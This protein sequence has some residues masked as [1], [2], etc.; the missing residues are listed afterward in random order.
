MLC[1]G[2]TCSENRLCDNISVFMIRMHG[3]VYFDSIQDKINFCANIIEQDLTRSK[4]SKST[5]R[6]VT[7]SNMNLVA[8]FLHF[9]S[10]NLGQSSDFIALLGGPTFVF[11]SIINW[12][13]MREEPNNTSKL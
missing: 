1:I 3:I 12:S 6:T 8:H 11:I 10:I 13:S 4:T 7:N 9:S 2:S 5:H